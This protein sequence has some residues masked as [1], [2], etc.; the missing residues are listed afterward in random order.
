MPRPTQ[1]RAAVA[2]AIC[3]LSACAE[4]TA[5]ASGIDEPIPSA[6][7]LRIEQLHSWSG[8]NARE[9]WLAA[10]GATIELVER[11][12]ATGAGD[13]D[14][15]MRRREELQEKLQSIGAGEVDG[16]TEAGG[17]TSADEA[18]GFARILTA[19]TVS[20]IYDQ[21]ASSSGKVSTLTMV[22]ATVVITHNITIKKNINGRQASNPV[23]VTDGT[24]IFLPKR[25]HMTS[26]SISGLDCVAGTQ[27][28]ADAV[29]SATAWWTKDATGL[30]GDKDSCGPPPPCAGSG[31][32]GP[33]DPFTGNSYDPYSASPDVAATADEIS[34]DCTGDGT[35]GGG[36][37]CTIVEWYRS[38]DGGATWEYIGTSYYC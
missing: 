13:R 37:E 18:E 21:G 25:S 33:I 36:A 12:L 1:Y 30:S 17:V 10:L 27:I 24:G 19:E 23:T 7:T 34:S 2:V 29:H 35:G 20:S 15:L 6:E 26:V 14:A 22:D 32:S 28:T 11:K 4:V 3:T 16:D 38:V 8:E 31:G 5:P 9:Q